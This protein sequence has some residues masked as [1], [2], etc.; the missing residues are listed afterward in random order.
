MQIRVRFFV[1]KEMRRSLVYA[2]LTH[3]TQDFVEVSDRSAIRVDRRRLD[4]LSLG[5][6]KL[7]GR[8]RVGFRYLID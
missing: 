2:L 6:E 4:Q 8:Q 3:F 7:F 1:G 5:H